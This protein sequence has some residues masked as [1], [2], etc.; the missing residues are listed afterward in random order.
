MWCTKRN[1]SLD[2]RLWFEKISNIVPLSQSISNYHKS[3]LRKVGMIWSSTYFPTL[4]GK[5]ELSVY[6][7]F[8]VILAIGENPDVKFAN[9][10][11]VPSLLARDFKPDFFYQRQ[12]QE[13]NR[14]STGSNWKESGEGCNGI[15]HKKGGKTQNSCLH[16]VKRD[17]AHP[18]SIGCHF[19][20][21]LPEFSFTDHG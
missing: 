14:L 21:S 15:L 1:I 5:N 19:W 10:C 18:D 20:H 6:I 9:F 8:A 16:P 2:R 11:S 3:S 13:W 4:I 7:M 17:G 12:T